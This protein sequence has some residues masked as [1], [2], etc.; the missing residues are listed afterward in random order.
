MRDA[1]DEAFVAEVGGRID[2]DNFR[3]HYAAEM[4]TSAEDG[5]AIG[6]NNYYL[7]HR[8]DTDR[9]VFLPHGQDV[10]FDDPGLEAD[11]PPAA[12]LAARVHD[13]PARWAE[14]ASV[15]GD[16]LAPGGAFDP[17]A[18]AARADEAAAVITS[19]DRDD[20]FTAGDLAAFARRL[21]ELKAQVA[22]RATWLR[23]EAAP[24]RCGDGVVHRGEQC[25]D[26]NEVDGDGCDA[27]C[28]PECVEIMDGGSTWRLCPAAWDRP[29]AAARCVDAGGALVVPASADEAAALALMIRRALG[30]VDVW[31]GVTDAATDGVWL[32]ELGAAPPYLGFAGSEPNGGEAEACAVLDTGTAGGWRDQPCDVGYASLCRL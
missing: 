27:T 8:P 23:G 15:I 3:R 22:W 28:R 19:T 4:L 29:T 12:R 30:N 17:D 10:T 21:P 31:I 14:V 1:T 9:F 13:Q 11:Y 25:D 18:L 24:L 32:D 20:A 26:G 2:L 6:R 16:A 7:Y 5:H